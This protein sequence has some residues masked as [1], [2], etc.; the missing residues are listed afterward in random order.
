MDELITFGLLCLTSFF[1]LINPLGTMPIFL[2]MTNDLSDQERKHTAKKASLVSFIIIIGFALSGQLLFK[3]FGISVNSFKVVGGVIFFMMG[4]DMLQARLSA[5][6]IKKNEVKTYVNDISITPLAIPMICGPG[7]ITNAIVLME[8]ANSYTKIIIL[9]VTIA[10]IVFITYLILL[11]STKIIKLIGQ[12]GI[13][14]MMRLMGLIVM[15]IAVE[16]FFSGLKPI[17]LDIIK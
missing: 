9:L 13:N 15:V 16:F 17:I 2:T 10:V 6:K 4:M 7:A 14:V 1:T 12:T 3:F 5:V 11:S 8:D